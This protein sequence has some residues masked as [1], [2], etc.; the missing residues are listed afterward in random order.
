MY[1]YEISP[2]DFWEGCTLLEDYVSKKLKHLIETNA[3][4]DAYAYGDL[5]DILNF[6]DDAKKMAKKHGNF[7]DDLREGGG[8]YVAGIPREGY[9]ECALMIMWKQDNSGTTY[10][11]SQI[12][13]PWLKDDLIFENGVGLRSSTKE[14]EDQEALNLEFG[15]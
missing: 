6:F 10:V 5:V 13:L 4:L 1:I 2:I 12:Y 11:A 15:G 9:P 3:T 7:E 8:P 14:I